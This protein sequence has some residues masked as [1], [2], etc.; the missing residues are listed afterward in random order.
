M[1]NRVLLGGIS[2]ILL[3]GGLVL[4]TRWLH[5]RSELARYEGAARNIWNAQGYR[6]VEVM[7]VGP[8]PSRVLER[9]LRNRSSTPGPQF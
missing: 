8:R 7:G 2:M 6:V 5:Q 1:K 9:P 3:F 4:G